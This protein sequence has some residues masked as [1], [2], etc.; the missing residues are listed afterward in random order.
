MT[1][2]RIINC[3]LL[4]LCLFLFG[5]LNLSAGSANLSFSGNNSVYEGDTVSVTL[6]IS[7]VSNADGGVAGIVGKIDY[8]SN[9]L[10]LISTQNKAP[11]NISFT[12]GP[13]K[14]SG[15]AGDDSSTIK[16]SSSIMTFTFKAK[17]RGSARISFSGAD[18]SDMKYNTVSVNNPSFTIKIKA[19]LSGNNN[20]SSLSVSGGS[21]N[22]NPNTTSYSIKVGKDV[23]SVNI[24]AQAEDGGA[25]VSGTGNRTIN[26]GSNSLQVVVTA[27]NA[28]KKTYT[29]NVTR[30]DPRSSNNNLSNLT[31]SGV[32]LKPKFKAGTTT[33]EVTVPFSMENLNIKATPEDKKAKV[34]ISNQNGLPAEATTDV[35]V[36][37]TAENGSVKT[38]T[39]KVTREKDPNKPKSGN[40]Y[41]SSLTTNIGI[42]SPIF[43]KEKLNYV[44]YL[45]FEVD[46]IELNATVDDTKYGVL[47][48]SGP[49]TLNVG[50]NKYTFKV[51]TEDGTSRIYTVNVIRGTNVEGGTSNVLLKELGIENG[52][53][54]TP[55]KNDINVYRYNK[56]KGFKINPIPEDENTKITVLEHDN[57]YTIIL[58]GNN[59][60][61][62]VY[63]LIPKEKSQ[64]NMGLIIAFI[65]ASVPL[66]GGGSYI[67]YRIGLKKMLSKIKTLKPKDALVNNEIEY[68]ESIKEEKTLEKPKKK[69][70]N[71][72]EKNKMEK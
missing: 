70:T 29:I 3:F 38:Y 36:K 18:F 26:Y 54:D 25:S 16:S 10:E 2:R 46:K 21:I 58:E 32:D 63:T 11:F 8:D 67:G 14:F 43:D 68:K 47:E 53:L 6:S 9:L 27:A 59:G 5:S 37:V 30:E 1:N 57:V 66:I 39:I 31:I 50:N 52:S 64:S 7:G 41:L 13:N 72:K 35:L 44:I 42:L 65:I 33:Y 51:T 48:K 20:L 56:K 4:S 34:S 15:F 17:T 40:N 23:S 61:T 12:P 22:F 28:S 62:N 69:K 60:E 19:P 49:E 45:P 55:F 71:P 24:T